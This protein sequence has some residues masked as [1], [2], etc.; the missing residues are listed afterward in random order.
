MYRHVFEHFRLLLA[1]QVE[2]FED[3]WTQAACCYVTVGSAETLSLFIVEEDRTSQCDT[4]S[5]VEGR[6]TISTADHFFRP[7]TVS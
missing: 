7:N 2:N 5:R 1:T 4:K 6:G 3:I